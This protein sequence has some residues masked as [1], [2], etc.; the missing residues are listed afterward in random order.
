M[1]HR[2]PSMT[3]TEWDV[4]YGRGIYCY[5]KRAGVKSSIKRGM[6]RRER[7]RALADTREVPAHRSRKD[8]KRWCRGK[9]GVEHQPMIEPRRDGGC[10]AILWGG[11]PHEDHWFCMHQE[12]CM[13][14]G[15]ILDVWLPRNR[16]PDAILAKIN[17]HDQ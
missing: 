6:R 14:C 4:L 13:E 3:A 8:T 17:G 7:R 16:C 11:P 12:V 10:H 9:V 5:L 15:K 1:G 2:T